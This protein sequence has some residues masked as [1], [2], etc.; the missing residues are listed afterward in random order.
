MGSLVEQ[1]WTIQCTCNCSL[2]HCLMNILLYVYH[3][4]QAM[5]NGEWTCEECKSAFI[6]LAGLESN[7][8]LKLVMKDYYCRSYNSCLQK[9]V[10]HKNIRAVYNVYL[11]NYIYS[12]HKTDARTIIR[13]CFYEISGMLCQLPHSGCN[14][15]TTNSMPVIIFMTYI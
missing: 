4:R 13:L 5:D 14:R 15:T 10:W 11:L 9:G 7:W 1:N 8:F 2:I 3:S 6:C 12:Q